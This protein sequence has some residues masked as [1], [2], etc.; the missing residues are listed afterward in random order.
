MITLATISLLFTPIPT[1]LLMCM[2]PE[3]VPQIE[4]IETEPARISPLNIKQT[5]IDTAR[6]KGL[7]EALTAQ[8]E[9]TINCESGWDPDAVGDYGT[10]FG[11]VQIH[12]PA[13][14]YV[15]QEQA[16]DPVFAIN[17][18]TDEFA[19]GNQRIWT[20]YRRLYDVQ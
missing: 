20:C 18:I 2:P 16:T 4:Q 8:I 5:L 3:P 17:F 15:T 14:P 6:A 12:L 7:S 9:N 11:L 1:P 19:R 13:H 10:S